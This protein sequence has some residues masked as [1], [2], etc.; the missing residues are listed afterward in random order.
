MTLVSDDS[1]AT[2]D[3]RLSVP[4]SWRCGREWTVGH[5]WPCNT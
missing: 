4:D 5:Q 1:D 2:L 3:G